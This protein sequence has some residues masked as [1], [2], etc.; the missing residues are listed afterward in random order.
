MQPARVQHRVQC[1][2]KTGPVRRAVAGEVS[3]LA[4]EDVD[5]D[6][7][8]EAHHD[9]VGYETQHRSEPEQTGRGHD[10]PGQHGQGEQGPGGVGGVVNG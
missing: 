7:V 2:G 4:E 10:H 9:R 1:T 3:Q 8:D 5:P 6:G